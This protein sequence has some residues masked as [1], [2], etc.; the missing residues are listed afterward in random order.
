MTLLAGGVI[1]A[2]SFITGWLSTRF[3]IPLLRDRCLDIP[4]ERSSHSSPV[5]RGGGIGLIAGIAA[6]LLTAKLFGIDMPG[7]QLLSAAA[8]IG[9]TGFMDDRGGGLPIALR[10]ALQTAAAGIVVN[11]TGGMARVPLPAPL[12]VPLGSIAVPAALIW[13]VGITNLYNFLDGIDGFAALQGVIAGL[14]I[15]YLD[16]GGTGALGL[17]AAAACAGFL[18]LN[19][20]PAKVFMGDTGAC[21]LGLLFAA[22]ALYMNKPAGSALG[23]V[24]FLWFFLSDGIFT[25]I[26]RALRGERV[27]KAHRSHLYQRL[28]R[29]G[30]RHGH[31]VSAVGLL[32]ALVTVVGAI[33][34]RASSVSGQW[35]ALGLGL[36]GFV[37]YYLWTRAREARADDIHRVSEPRPDT[38]V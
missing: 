27:W 19:W 7:W 6:G 30:L 13:I 17:A 33:A 23:I 26:C 38:A 1:L 29:S 37:F 21:T 8:L 25:L 18:I 4:N 11:G 20:H 15:A 9:L 31:V 22:A 24:F 14:A 35:S 36:G 10:L 2:I 16:P 5:P 34:I 3:A 32:S 12:D 28:V